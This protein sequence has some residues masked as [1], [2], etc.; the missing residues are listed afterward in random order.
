[1]AACASTSKGWSV[2]DFA[3]RAPGLTDV[4]LSGRLGDGPQGLVFNGPGERSIGRPENAGGLA[5]GAA[6]SLPVRTKADRARR[7]HDCQRPL[8]ARSTVGALD[9]E[10]VEG[11]LAYTWAVGDRPAALDGE[12]HATKLN[13]DALAAF[14]KAAAADSALR[15]CRTA[16][17]S[18]S[19]SARRRSPASTRERSMPGSSSIPAYCIST[20]CRSAISAAP[21]ST[22]AAASTNCRRS[23]AAGSRSTSTPQR[24]P[25]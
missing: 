8:C 6:T 14:V 17:R 2:D 15:E 25:V 3:F 24:W 21:R 20:G 16:S 7:R 11:R 18:C 23:R 12:L 4:N 9:R 10:N 1:M 5:R 19:M 13:V 22:S